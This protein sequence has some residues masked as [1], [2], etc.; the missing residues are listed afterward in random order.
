M[1]FWTWPKAKTEPSIH[2]SSA[3]Q[4]RDERNAPIICLKFR[5]KIRKKP[6]KPARPPFN[7]DETLKFCQKFEKATNFYNDTIKSG[8]SQR[9]T[10]SKTAVYA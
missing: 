8:E 10:F 1:P 3:G 6:E 4:K 5:I 7:P 9:I 2:A